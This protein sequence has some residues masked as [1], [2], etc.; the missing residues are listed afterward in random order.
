MECSVNEF[1]LQCHLKDDTICDSL[2]NYHKYSNR[3]VKGVIGHGIYDSEIK[4]STDV[5]LLE[6]AVR[7]KYLKELQLVVDKYI[8]TFEYSNHYSPWTVLETINIQHYLPNQGF[9]IWHTERTVPTFPRS[10]RHLVFMTYL[11]DV[12][13]KGETEWYYQKLKVKPRKGLTV[14]WPADWTHTH[15]GI[16]SPTQ[17]KYV[18]TGWFNYYEKEN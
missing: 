16:P 7:E 17:E 1:I 4:D 8:E 9:K 14:I 12:D 3:K 13:D 10:A 11:N 6:G 5:A 15:R 18:V 2:I